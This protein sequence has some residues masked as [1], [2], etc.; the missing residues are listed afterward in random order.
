MPSPY[1]PS[2]IQPA[3]PAA[4]WARGSQF[5]LQMSEQKLRAQQM[6]QQMQARQEEGQRQAQQFAME[7]ELARE[8]MRVQSQEARQR[9]EL[10]EKYFSQAAK[11]AADKAAAVLEY[12][13]AIEGG[14]DPT[15]A[16]L[17]YGPGM[18]QATAEAAALRSQSAAEALR[19]R[20]EHQAELLKVRREALAATQKRWTDQ[21]TRP[22][23]AGNKVFDPK[24]GAVI[25]D[26]DSAK[27]TDVDKLEHGRALASMKEASAALRQPAISSDAEK[28][29]KYEA[30]YDAAVGQMDEIEGRY[31]KPSAAPPQAEGAT[32]AP[33][34][35][36]FA[37]KVAG[38]LSGFMQGPLAAPD[39]GGLTGPSPMLQGAPNMP[40]IP[41]AAPP[42]P[43]IPSGVSA[44]APGGEIM[45]MTKDGKQAIFDA[46][47]KRF[48]RY[49]DDQAAPL[50]PSQET[51]HDEEEE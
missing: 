4:A 5:G 17:K 43:Q 30:Q 34:V 19:Q 48:L 51:S 36:P 28:V 6:A 42:Q 46:A 18:G 40:P 31:K 20:E 41:A 10:E 47:T 8:R 2:W 14:M 27:M 35:S 45:R 39:T 1:I 24:T 38:D 49:A 3:D 50:A 15:K 33:A 21:A 16:I 29:A 9:A 25:F 23:H 11:L 32:S 26:A 12:Q 22:I 7:Q 13:Q 37:P 44:S